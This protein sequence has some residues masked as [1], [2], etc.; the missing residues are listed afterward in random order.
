MVRVEGVT[1][2]AG[3]LNPWIGTF[4]IGIL[5]RPTTPGR[6]LDV[7]ATGEAGLDLDNTSGTL[8]AAQFGADFLTAAKIADAAFVADNFAASSLNGKGDWNTVVPPTEAQMNAR[9]I[10][11]ADYVVVGDTLARVTLVDTTTALTGKT[12]F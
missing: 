6:T 3:T 12:G 7:N 4:E 9:T 10:V 8:D 11:S 1:V 2:D 5:L